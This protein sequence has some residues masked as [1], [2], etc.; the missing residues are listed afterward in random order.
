[1]VS[2]PEARTHTH[3]DIGTCRRNSFHWGRGG[4]GGGSQADEADGPAT[5][6]SSKRLCHRVSQASLTRSATQP[7]A[8]T[9]SAL[10]RWP[11]P[12]AVIG[13]ANTTAQAV[14]RDGVLARS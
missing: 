6:E 14:R 2:Q 12:P 4:G 11:S 7:S 1:M 8:L 9:R 10:T 13:P 3:R 5:G